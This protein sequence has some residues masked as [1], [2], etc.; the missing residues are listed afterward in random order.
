MWNG[1]EP[2]PQGGED[3]GDGGGSQSQEVFI[4]EA[5]NNAGTE[6]SEQERSFKVGEPAQNY[7]LS[8]SF[9]TSHNYFR[10]VPNS[11]DE[12]E[13]LVCAD[14]QKNLN[15]AKRKKVMVKTPD[16]SPKGMQYH[17]FNKHKNL[18]SKIEEQKAAHDEKKKQNQ[19][20]RAEKQIKKEDSMK[21]QKL[22][23][24][25]DGRS[26]AVEPRHDPQMQRRLDQAVVH[27]A[28]MTGISF[29]ALSKENIEILIKAFFPK[30]APKVH[31]RHR[32]TISRHTTL[33]ADKVR[34]DI[35]SIILSAKDDCSSFSF[36]SDMWR[37]LS[38]DS[39]ISLSQHF[40]TNDGTLIKLIPYCEYFGKR[41]HTG[42]N[43]KISLDDMMRGLQLD[44]EKFEKIVVLD[45]A[46]NNK[47]CIRLSPNLIGHWCA[48][49][50]LAL[51]VSATMKEEVMSIPV[52]RVNK[53]CK[54]ISKFV[55]SSE[56]RNNELRVACK[57]KDI[58]YKLPK[59]QMPV[60]WNSQ[61]A[62]ISS[63]VGLRHA[64]QFLMFNT[65]EGWDEE[66]ICLTV[67]EFKLAESMVKVLAP[68]K[69]AT[70]QWE[71]DLTPSIHLVITEVY[72]IQGAMAEFK[73]SPDKYVSS[74]AEALSR[75]VDARFPNCATDTLIYS[76]AHMLDP[77]FKGAILHEFDGAFMRAKEEIIRLGSRHDV[78]EKTNAP[79]A[80]SAE[81]EGSSAEENLTPAQKL[82]R[83][84]KSRPSADM[85]A[86]NVT[87][88]QPINVRRE[89]DEYLVM[90]G[91]TTQEEILT[92]WVKHKKM[93]PILFQ[94]VRMV[95][96]IPAS[97]ST[98]E[99]IFSQG[100]KV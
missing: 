63:V 57:K 14:E 60:R 48:N 79:I 28:A 77:S 7:R 23:P 33:E 31:G 32:S 73:K 37:N 17:L 99:R 64:L 65:A 29:N 68:A 9:Y 21:Q 41:K 96:A 72:N 1:I 93:F 15:A 18:K 78:T 70:K 11:P 89:L 25:G 46:A 44:D 51:A 22:V 47:C 13:C 94:I 59:K 67:Q 45:N 42:M 49:H 66:K 3:E 55:R 43:I 97:S 84:Q 91:D 24:S 88:S 71:K 19:K 34:R 56:L 35:L 82:L 20:E 4:V 6:T 69:F 30:S 39:F 2:P 12:A 62:N 83:K 81:P 38:L 98:S 53:K 95:L 10:K 58:K 76:V 90:E 52:K 40:I 8:E 50:S 27:F 75:N 92:W 86:A 87:V 26:L 5:N 54:E 36:T 85:V 61:E 80:V 100:T 74:F 16:N